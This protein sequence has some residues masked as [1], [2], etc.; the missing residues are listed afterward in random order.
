MDTAIDF[1][2]LRGM[3]GL[4]VRYRGVCC[5]IVE[6]LQEDLSV[7]LADLE[8]HLG[9]Q[10]DQHGE[11]HRRVPKTYTIPICSNGSTELSAEFLD[12]EPMTLEEA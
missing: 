1:E 7:V 10:A 12:I 6:I 2:K 8:A 4:R 9:I 11:A 5:E 3:I